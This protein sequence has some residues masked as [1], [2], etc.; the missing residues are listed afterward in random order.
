MFHVE[1][2]TPCLSVSNIVDTTLRHATTS[3][4]G[5]IIAWSIDAKGQAT[6]AGEKAK[7]CGSDMFTALSSSMNELAVTSKEFEKVSKKIK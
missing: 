2:K 7:A 4:G 1:H 6:R 5:Q 3:N